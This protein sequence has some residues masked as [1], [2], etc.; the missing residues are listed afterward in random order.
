MGYTRRMLVPLSLIA[1][2]LASTPTHTPE[3]VADALQEAPS[4]QAVADPEIQPRLREIPS[5]DGLIMTVDLYVP[6]KHR[7]TPMI[8]LFHQAGWSRGEYREIA[9]QLCRM[10]YNC[11]AVDLRSGKEV[12]GVLNET[13]RRAREG[14]LGTEYADALPD[15]EA[16]LRYARKQLTQGPVIAWGSSYSSALVLQLAGTQPKLMDGVLSFA[17][18]E[19]FPDKPEDWIQSAARTIAC[20]TFVTSAKAEHERWKAIF[21]AIP[22]AKKT[23]F[24]PETKGQHGSRALWKRFEDSPAYWKAVQTFLR[25]HF[26]PKP[27]MVPQPQKPAKAPADK[28]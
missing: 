28:Q 21:E 27:S 3:P 25:A 26:A 14:E 6:N 2:A 19:Y 5:K 1:L 8:V 13:A 10:G 15:M 12:N 22:H 11:M 16:A 20:P 9:P 23:A 17:P 4:A 18:G 7:E 24:V